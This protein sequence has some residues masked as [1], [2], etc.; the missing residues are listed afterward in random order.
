MG[1]DAAVDRA[2]SSLS[3][4][5]STKV[6]RVQQGPLVFDHVVSSGNTFGWMDLIKTCLG[7]IFL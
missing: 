3:E 5:Y 1:Q 7:H 4:T 6:R 2:V